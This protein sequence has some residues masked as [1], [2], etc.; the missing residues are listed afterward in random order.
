VR[1]AARA[2]EGAANAAL[3]AFLAELFEVRKNDVKIEAGD[4]SR[5]KRV[6]VLGSRCAPDAL[7]SD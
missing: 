7:I 6:S 3:I 2:V 1:L 4:S 5:R